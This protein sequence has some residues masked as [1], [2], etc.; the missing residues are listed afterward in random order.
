MKTDA[1]RK[2]SLLYA[3]TGSVFGT[4][5]VVASVVFMNNQAVTP[6]RDAVLVG[7]TIKV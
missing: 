2:R 4:L 6:Y 7:S 5:L 1:D 3:L